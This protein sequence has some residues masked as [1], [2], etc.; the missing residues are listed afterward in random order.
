MRDDLQLSARMVA[1]LLAHIFG[2]SWYD[3]PRYGGVDLGSV[4]AGPR[5]EPWRVAGPSPIRGRQ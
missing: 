1:S 2:P 3:G 4:V 5:P